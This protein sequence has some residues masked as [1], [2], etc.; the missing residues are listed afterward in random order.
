M[1]SQQCNITY[2]QYLLPAAAFGIG[3]SVIVFLIITCV[4]GIYCRAQKWSQGSLGSYDRK[5]KRIEYLSTKEDTRA[6]AIIYATSLL[7]HA[8]NTKGYAGETLGERLSSAHNIFTANN[9]IWK[10]HRL[11]NQLAH[12]ADMKQLDVEETKQALKVIRQA[13]FDLNVYI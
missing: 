8:L 5:W 6:L 3:F 13:L 9:Q 12:D 11:R 7:G 1:T 4:K 10:V 2:Q